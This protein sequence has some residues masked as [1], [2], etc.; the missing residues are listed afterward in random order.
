[1][2][3]DSTINTIEDKTVHIHA[4]DYEKNSDTIMYVIYRWQQTSAIYY[5]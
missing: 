4:R 3:A 2:P 1:M 5:I